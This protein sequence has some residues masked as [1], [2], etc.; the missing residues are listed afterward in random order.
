MPVLLLLIFTSS[1]PIKN[2][3]PKDLIFFNE[4]HGH[5]TQISVHVFQVGQL[6]PGLTHAPLH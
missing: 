6:L 3:I 4:N 1:L 5:D 2:D